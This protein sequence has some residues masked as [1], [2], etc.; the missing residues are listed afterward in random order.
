MSFCCCQYL[1]Q[2]P[3]T[4]QQTNLFPAQPHAISKLRFYLSDALWGGRE[5]SIADACQCK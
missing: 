4:S 3:E 5:L 1:F 2:T